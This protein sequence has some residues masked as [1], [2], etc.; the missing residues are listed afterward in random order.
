MGMETVIEIR[1]AVDLIVPS[2]LAP[3]EAKGMNSVSVQD[4]IEEAVDYARTYLSLATESYSSIHT[5]TWVGGQT[6]FCYMS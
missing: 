2:C 5:L 6:S 4:E 1:S 3:L